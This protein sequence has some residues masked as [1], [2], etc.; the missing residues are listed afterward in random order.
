[1]KELWK[2]VTENAVFVAEF[3]GIVVALFLIAIVI[4]KLADKKNGR[5]RKI[6]TTRM[7]TMVGM[8]SAMATVLFMMDFPLPFLAPPFYKVDFSELPVMIGTFAFGPVAGVMIEFCKI[9]LELIIFGTD[10]AFVG[11]LANFTIGCSLLLPASMVY[12]F[13]KSKKRA[14]LGCAMGVLCMTIFGT[15]LNAVFLLP[16][17]AQ[18]YGMPL[19]QIVAMGTTVNKGITDVTSFVCLAVGPLNILKGTVIS[20]ITMLIYKPLSPIIKCGQN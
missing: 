13:K 16:K 9:L 12:E 19:E 14:V 7:M 11:E 18:L 1:M 3:L 6:F 2:Q 17:F 5:K 10:T 8:L 20:V 4:Q 15:A